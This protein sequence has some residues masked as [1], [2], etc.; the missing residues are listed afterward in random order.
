M[1]L[2][3][4]IKCYVVYYFKCF[5]RYRVFKCLLRVV[6]WINNLIK[7]IKSYNIFSILF[8]VFR[9]LILILFEIDLFIFV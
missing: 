7:N 8:F 1:Y 6:Y 5:K 3:V 9:K 2:K 4:L